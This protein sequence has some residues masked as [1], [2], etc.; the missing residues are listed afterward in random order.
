M[1]QL[2]LTINAISFKDSVV[3]NNPALRVF[4]LTLK[5]L[6]QDSLKPKAEDFT[7]APGEEKVVFS[8]TKSM[9]IDN[10]TQLSIT[11]PNPN[12]S[13]YYITHTGGTNP[14]FRTERAIGIDNTTALSIS[15]N[16]P[17]MTLT[18]V[19][20]TALNTANIVIGDILRLGNSVSLSNQ[21][22]FEVLSKTATSITVK[23]LNAAAESVAIQNEADM[24]FYS[25]GG[26]SSNQV[27]KLDKLIISGGFSSSSFGTYEIVD[28]TSRFIVIKASP[29]RGLAIES[30]ISPTASGFIVYSE[31]KKFILI[32]AQQKISVKINQ[33]TGDN[34]I[35]EPVEVG[36]P[37]RS[38]IYLKEGSS[39][40]LTIKNL[41]LS[42]AEV[43]IAT[44]E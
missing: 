36:N 23:N 14:L 18:Y 28:V 21:G 10:S 33:E 31:A 24:I 8:G 37:E 40:S 17:L 42:T 9:A 26:G 38:G 29:E 35:V 7:L 27:Q 13:L 25:S 44:A 15:V 2:N 43:L 20:G 39:Y 1:P 22:S 3:S 12:E 30:A 16:G 19:S 34:H 6:G 5:H 4:D 11:M 32:S 41:S